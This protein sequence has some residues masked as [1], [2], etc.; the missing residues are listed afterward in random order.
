M[1]V[2][3]ETEQAVVHLAFVWVEDG[4]NELSRVQDGWAFVGIEYLCSVHAVC[5]HCL[6]QELLEI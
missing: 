2:G 6:V 4:Q 5:K 1:H 3:T